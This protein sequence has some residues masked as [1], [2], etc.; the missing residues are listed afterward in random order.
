MD[1]E[2]P[3]VHSECP[4][5]PRPLRPARCQL[6]APAPAS[7][8]RLEAPPP[9]APATQALPDEGEEWGPQSTLPAPPRPGPASPLGDQVARVAP[10]CASGA[11]SALS[12][13]HPKREKR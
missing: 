9:E 7:P 8:G 11:H 12:L 1:P 2:G 10:C 5:G 4:P 3:T 6:P 13:H